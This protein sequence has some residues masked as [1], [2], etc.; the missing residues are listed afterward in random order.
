MSARGVVKATASLRILP[1]YAGVFPNTQFM[2]LSVSFGS[3]FG[4]FAFFIGTAPNFIVDILHLP[5]TAFG[6]LFVPLVIGMMSGS[7][8]VPGRRPD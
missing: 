2:L 3:A 4:G 5:E 7:W 6:W 8:A 1:C